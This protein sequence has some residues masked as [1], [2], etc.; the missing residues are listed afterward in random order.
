MTTDPGAT[1]PWP[2]S[3]KRVFKDTFCV[4][5]GNL[6][7][8][9]VVAAAYIALWHLSFWLPDDPSE[10]AFSWWN[11]A[12]G[13]L[14]ATAIWGLASAVLIYVVLLALSGIR[15]SLRDLMRGF[16]FAVPVVVVL[17]ICGLPAMVSRLVG[18]VEPSETPAMVTQIAIGLAGSILAAFWFAAAPAVVAEGLGPLAALKRSTALTAG[19]RWRIFGLL[20]AIGVAFWAVPWVIWHVG[21]ALNAEVGHTGPNLIFWIGDYVFPA[22]GLVF[23]SVLQTVAYAAL[24]LAKEGAGAQELARVFD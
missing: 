5:M 4:L 1:S 12:V 8:C 21:N 6:R 13:E 3:I 16:S 10:D 9:A 17:F 7:G 24:R 23:W 20:L 18:A 2:F 15:P 11:F 22:V 14:L 19:W